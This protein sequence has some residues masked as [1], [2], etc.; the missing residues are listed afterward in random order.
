MLTAK[1]KSWADTLVYCRHDGFHTVGLYP[2]GGSTLYTMER[3]TI[4]ATNVLT[5]TAVL[6]P[7]PAPDIEVDLKNLQ[8]NEGDEWQLA[9]TYGGLVLHAA[10]A[11]ARLDV[12]TL[13]GQLVMTRR[14]IPETPIDL[15]ALPIGAYVATAAVGDQQ[16]TLKFSKP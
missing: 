16:T 10:T 8:S 4:G 5:T 15:S 3:P 7:E 9:Y 2:D 12:Y 6:W 1:D 14:I 11:Y 13:S